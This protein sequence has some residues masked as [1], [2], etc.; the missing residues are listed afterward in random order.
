MYKTPIPTRNPGPSPPNTKKL[1]TETRLTAVRIIYTIV[2]LADG[3]SIELSLGRDIR[4]AARDLV[5]H[6]LARRIVREQR[7]GLPYGREVVKVL[8]RRRVVIR[9]AFGV[10]VCDII[11]A[12]ESARG[13]REV[14]GGR[15]KGGPEIW[16]SDCSEVW[17]CARTV[18]ARAA[19]AEAATRPRA[20]KTNMT[21][22]P[23]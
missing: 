21:K 20:H 13:R 22:N 6:R 1:R 9:G 3:A 19:T 17:P 12:R 8:G 2:C 7:R 11:G 4:N 14:L 5:P 18:V 10:R 15:I 16:A 23:G